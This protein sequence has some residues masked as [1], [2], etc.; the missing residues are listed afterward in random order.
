MNQF[1]SVLCVT[2]MGSLEEFSDNKFE[3]LLK[4]FTKQAY[5]NVHI[6][7][8]APAKVIPRVQDLVKNV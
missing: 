7:I 4:S 2:I 3:G 6:P 5:T 1:L 8:F